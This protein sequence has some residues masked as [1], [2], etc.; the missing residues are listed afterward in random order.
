M[1]T[2]TP[3]QV[4]ETLKV[5][6]KE[7]IAARKTEEKIKLTKHQFNMIT[8]AVECCPPC[9]TVGVRKNTRHNK[10]SKKRNR[11]AIRKLRMSIAKTSPHDL[12]AMGLPDEEIRKL[13]TGQGLTQYTN[14]A[15]KK[16]Q[17]DL[18]IEHIYPL[19]YGSIPPTVRIN[20]KLFVNQ[21][22]VEQNICAIP[23]YLNNFF[24]YVDELQYQRASNAP[25]HIAFSPRPVHGKIPK[26]P[27]I[28][29]GFRPSDRSRRENEDR[30]SELFG[31]TFRYSPPSPSPSPLRR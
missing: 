20:N 19:S 3:R 6:F 12:A 2:P 24:S 5:A 27:K 30:I 28:P 8:I 9:L 15:K 23:Q 4:L 29:G 13:Q 16:L 21:Q 25:Y 14:R 26:V 31:F 10:T 1:S 18:T 11:K 22:K 7:S 17:Y